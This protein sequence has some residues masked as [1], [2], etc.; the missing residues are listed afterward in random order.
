MKD[1]D[2]VLRHD[3]KKVNEIIL[4]HLRSKEELV[5]VVS[6]YLVNSG[7]KRIRP[8]LTILCSKLFG[9]DGAEDVKLAAAVEFIHAATLLHDDVVD[10]SA[11]RR[12][13]D[14]ANIIWGNKTSILVGD[15]LFAQSF[16]LMVSAGSIDALRVLAN[17]SAIIAEGEVVQLVKLKEKLMISHEEYDQI[18]LAKTAEL[19]GAACAAGGIIA[20]QNDTVVSALKEFGAKL[21]FIFQI[22]DD[23][24]D[25]F[26][27]SDIG[28]N[29][30]D[31]FAEGKITLPIILASNKAS[32]EEKELLENILF[33]EN[34]DLAGFHAV[35]AVLK[36]YEIDVAL[37]D[38][39]QGLVRE[40]EALLEAIDGDENYKKHLSFLLHYAA[41][42][43]N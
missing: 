8:K 28:K 25:Y 22:A 33:S 3:V 27:A 14:S 37:R 2:H 38:Y 31:D 34:K 6:E 29:I 30:G 9:Y 15:F 12:F 40:G 26:A 16:K 18:I 4:S 32:S 39:M 24:L 10:N 5:E 17:A 1:L 42:R 35:L 41:A 20:G 36:K 7:G 43:V 23:M 13:K 19:F 21:G 11:M